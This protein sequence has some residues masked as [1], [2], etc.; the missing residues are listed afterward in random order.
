MMSAHTGE[1]LGWLILLAMAILAP[2]VV[3]D[4]WV[5]VLI[6]CYYAVL[7]C[8]AWNIVGGLAGQFAVGHSL[9]V[10]AGAYTS[11]V[12]LQR[13]GI[14]P[15]VGVI[16]GMAL[17]SLLGAFIAWLGFRYAL[18]HLS[19][20]LVTLALAVL[21]QLIL[22]STDYVG[23]SRGL[24]ISAAPSVL[25]FQFANDIGYYYVVLI[26]AILPI[27]FTRIIYDGRIGL[28][29]RAFRDNE[30]AARA[31]G[32]PVL[33]YRILAMCLSGGI[34]SLAG[35]FQAQYLLFVEP[36]TFADPMIVIQ[37]ILFVVVGGIGT[38]VGPIVGPL[39]MI[40]LGDLL[41]EMLG[42]ALPGLHLLGYGIIVVLIIR[43]A[44][45]GIV[46]LFARIRHG[47]SIRTAQIKP[48]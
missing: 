47:S 33:R 15:W 39:F 42:D 28:Y 24:T 29:F 19:F 21:G 35:T 30:D 18:A 32:I 8:A 10:A 14:S 5:N 38:V 6:A 26:F 40:P 36:H 4:H 44:P 48:I 23:A 25:M 46:G 2:L 45:G 22:S 7:L 9:F 20:A 11:T 27:A 37:T 43:L 16:G 12:L 13:F 17:S 31:I 3:S 34:T 41:R 1:A